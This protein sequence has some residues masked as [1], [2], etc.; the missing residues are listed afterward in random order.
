MRKHA[1]LKEY[2]P[3][4]KRTR[5]ACTAA[6]LV[7]LA[8]LAAACSS[9]GSGSPSSSP[10]GGA[11]SAPS[12]GN[13]IT[14]TGST[15]L[16]PLFGAWQ[17]AYNTANPNVNIY[18]AGTGS[19]TGITD[20]ATGTATIGGSDAY[21]SAADLQQYPGLINIPLNVSALMVNYNLPG[22][23]TPLKLN[24]T[25]LAKIY[26]GKITNWNDKA[27]AA[28][29]KGV[30]LPN[31]AITTLHRADSSGSTF[32]FVSYLNAQDPT[33]WA[34]GLVGT[35]VTWPNTPKT[36]AETGNGGMVTGCGTIKGCIAYIGIS[37]QSKTTA[38]NLGIASLANKTGG[39]TQPTP[40]AISAALASFSSSTPA[41]GSQP[42]INTSAASGYP[43]INYEY[44]VVQKKQPSA[45]EAS[46]LKAFLTW[47]ITTGATS[48]YL[49]AVNFQPLPS[50]V[51]S[52]AKTLI[53]SISG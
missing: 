13:T 1:Q 41:S 22:I 3:V 30:T 31:L 53:A 39:F 8:V 44:A 40:S 48:T 47:T 52:I 27:I 11:S 36:A 12:S 35:T 33:D 6:A 45:A 9:S 18:S 4:T 26:D 2:S 50:N 16:F 28:L 51:Q 10:S 21:L 46:A 23:K 49:S 5:L 37:Y 32:V 25:V 24:G 29:N 34:S 20:A 17:T 38:A 19:G 15:L 14:E 43:I 42:L 7:P